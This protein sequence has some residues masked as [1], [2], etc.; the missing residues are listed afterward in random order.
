MLTGLTSESSEQG[1]A[2]CIYSEHDGLM[3]RVQL[4]RYCYS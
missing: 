4:N 1:I 3:A 2:V